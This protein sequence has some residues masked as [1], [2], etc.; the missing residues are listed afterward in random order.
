VGFATSSPELSS[1]I[2]AV[3]IRR[4]KMAAGDIFGTDLFNIALIAS[5]TVRQWTRNGSV[6]PT[7]A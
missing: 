2:A 6:K 4:Y 5:A 7:A 1:I 3:R